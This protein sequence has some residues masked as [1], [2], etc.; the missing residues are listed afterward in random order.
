MN[1][2]GKF[3]LTILLSVGIAALLLLGSRVF[4]EGSKSPSAGTPPSYRKPASSASVYKVPNK[5]VLKTCSDVF[6]AAKKLKGST[7]SCSGSSG[8]WDLK[9]GIL[10][11]V[12]QKGDGSQNENQEKLAS[13]RM[14]LTIRNGFVRNNKDALTFYESNSGVERLTFT[15]LGEDGV[16]TSGNP[17][18]FFVKDCEFI[19][20]ASGDK[21]IQASSGKG[22]R[23]VGN[24]IF[25]GTTGIR[26]GDSNITKVSDMAEVGN[27][28]FVDLDT[29]YH[30]S[31]ITVKELTKSKFENV[32]QEWK[33]ANG[34][35]KK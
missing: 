30:P 5:F 14:K 32:R 9:G 31:K 11:G 1:T 4:A 6:N 28:R 15:N 25:A 21:S 7:A 3:L 35:Q 27:N 10:D 18:G 34:A 22:A 16:A 8:V 2:I 12:N 23:I 17:T 20:D 19:N 29:A 26:I 13:V 24:L 33:F